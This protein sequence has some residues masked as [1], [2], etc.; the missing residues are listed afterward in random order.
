MGRSVIRPLLAALAIVAGTATA[1]AQTTGPVVVELFTSQ[2]CS[3]CPP[4][5]A[6]LGKLAE[7]DDL[8]VLS[9]HVD[10]WD[11][12][13]WRDVF[14]AAAHTQ[15]QRNYAAAMRERSIYTP[16]MVIQGAEHVVGSQT[17]KVDEAIARQAATQQVALVGMRQKDDLL[18]TEIEPISATGPRQSGKVIMAWYTKAEQVQIQRGENRGRSIVYHNVVK[19]WAEIGDWNGAKMTLTASK[20]MGADGIAVMVQAKNGGQIFG[21]ARFSLD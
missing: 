12:L 15:R 9:L 7:R 13:G 5:D 21:A 18:I 20:P 16:Q 1:Q 2:G 14:G 17:A 6:Y 4:A 19:G 3:S 8:I 11:Y 10:Y